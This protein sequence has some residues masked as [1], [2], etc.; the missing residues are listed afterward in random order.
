LEAVNYIR[1]ASLHFGD[2]Y[3]C[4]NKQ[5]IRT[6]TQPAPHPPRHAKS[7][8]QDIYRFRVI[9]HGYVT[10]SFDGDSLNSWGYGLLSATPHNPRQKQ[11]KRE[12]HTNEMPFFYN[13][14]FGGRRAGGNITA[15][16]HGVHKPVF[17]FRLCG[18]NC[19][20]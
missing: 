15:D 6:A 8:S 4:L 16:R 10:I 1:F 18:F 5:N 14:G 19:F 20:R 17:R 9:S 11:T 13:K 12:S 2:V 3:P 7:L